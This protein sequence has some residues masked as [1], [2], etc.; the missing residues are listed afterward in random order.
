M[1]RRGL[2]FPESNLIVQPV[3]LVH[4]GLD[5]GIRCATNTFLLIRFLSA[6]G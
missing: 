1:N 3:S 5:D 2:F 6:S 4:D